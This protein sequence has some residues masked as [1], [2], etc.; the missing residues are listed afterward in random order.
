M[1]IH[2]KQSLDTL[3]MKGHTSYQNM[4]DIGTSLSVTLQQAD[5]CKYQ[6]VECAYHKYSTRFE[7]QQNINSVCKL[8]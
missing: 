7:L 3:V 6:R 4:D 5:K 1:S 8:G 2:Q